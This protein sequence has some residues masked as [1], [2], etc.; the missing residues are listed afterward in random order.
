[1]IMK[2]NTACFIQNRRQKQLLMKNILNTCLIQL[3]LRLYQTYK[4]FL[5]NVRFVLLIQL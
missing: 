2:Q 4:N 1:M 5:Y 3:I